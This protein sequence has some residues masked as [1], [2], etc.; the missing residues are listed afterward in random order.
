MEWLTLIASYSCREKQGQ[1]R[2]RFAPLVSVPIFRFFL[3]LLHLQIS[4]V[5]YESKH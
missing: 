2:L 4:N 3:A 5:N 1:T